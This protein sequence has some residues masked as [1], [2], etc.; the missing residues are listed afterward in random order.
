MT[1]LLVP[2]PRLLQF[3]KE[4]GWFK[5]FYYSVYSALCCKITLASNIMIYD[6]LKLNMLR[7]NLTNCI[8]LNESSKD[9]SHSSFFATAFR[10]QS[11]QY[12]ASCNLSTVS[13]HQI[14]AYTS[15]LIGKL[16]AFFVRKRKLSYNP[17]GKLFSV[18]GKE[19]H[20]DVGDKIVDQYRV[21]FW[22]YSIS[23]LCI[24]DTNTA[25]T[26]LDDHCLYGIE[27][28]INLSIRTF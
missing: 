25:I 15:D 22:N 4:E 28:K 1:M 23:T 14:I 7:S 2:L 12:A 19:T 17:S 24:G 10:D 5:D 27:Q 26:T 20:W 11:F 18:R 8:K 16:F 21:H 13:S 6:K 3:R 9:S